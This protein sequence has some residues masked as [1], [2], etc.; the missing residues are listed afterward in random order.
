[1]KKLSIFI[2]LI[3]SII[4]LT[5]C[6][7]Y[8][9]IEDLAIVAGMAIDIDANGSYIINVEIVD[10]KPTTTGIDL[11]P[12]I[13]ETRGETVFEA[14]RNIISTSLKR[15]RW[16]HAS[17]VVVSKEVAEQGLSSLLDW[18]ARHPEAR[19]TLHILIS[20]ENTAKEVILKEKEFSKIRALEFEKFVDSSEYLSKFPHVEVYELINKIENK[21]NYPILPT[22]NLININNEVYS[23]MEGS[24]YFI[25]DKLAGF[26]DPMET[27][28]YL[29]IVNKLKKGVLVIPM[30]EENNDKVSLDILKNNTKID[31]DFKDENVLITVKTNTVVSIAEVRD[32]RNYSNIKGRKLLQEHAE[33][34]LENEIK[35]F[36]QNVQEDPGIDVFSFGDKIKK[37][38]P[39]IWK[40]IED[41]WDSIFK[42]LN[43]KIISNIQI[44]N[45]EHIKRPISVN[46]QK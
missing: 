5:G 35:T 29:L 43:V 16:S 41:N 13:I 38:H 15:I 37:N 39:K 27:M 24:A 21:D 7:D 4:F 22:T 32:G 36:I 12:I 2:A 8:S 28:K 40:D 26:F 46:N 18:I 31:I 23:Q 45:S 9:E 20:R 1:M 3:I 44:R 14:L 33:A 11:A 34:Y 19:L 42:E 6:W 30:N 25:K 17:Y 10:I